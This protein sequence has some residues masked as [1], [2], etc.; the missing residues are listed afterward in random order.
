MLQFTD[1]ANITIKIDGTVLQDNA[2]NN[3]YWLDAFSEVEKIRKV[4]RGQKREWHVA[5]QKSID[6]LPTKLKIAEKYTWFRVMLF[7]G[8]IDIIAT[9]YKITRIKV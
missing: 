4:M 1:C 9:N 6:P 3:T 7:G 8:N 5:Y 2:P